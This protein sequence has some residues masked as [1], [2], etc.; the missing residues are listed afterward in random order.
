[1]FGPDVVDGVGVIAVWRR[2][3]SRS[4]WPST[5]WARKPIRTPISAPATVRPAGAKG[6]WAIRSPTRAGERLEGAAEAAEVG[7]DPLLAV[8]DQ[9]P[10]RVVGRDGEAGEL[11][12]EL[13]RPGGDHVELGLQGGGQIRRFERVVAGDAPRPAAPPAP[14]RPVP[15]RRPGCSGGLPPHLDAVLQH[16]DLD[17]IADDHHQHQP[18]EA[19]GQHRR[20]PVVPWLGRGDQGAGR[21]PGGGASGRT[22]PHGTGAPRSHPTR[23]RAVGGAPEMS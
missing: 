4:Y 23:E 9:G 19:D 6:L 1:M 8:E 22:W 21:P 12:D 17:H 10:G 20:Q 16:D 2:R 7:V 11:P 3:P 14:S 13:L 15:E 18:D 5:R